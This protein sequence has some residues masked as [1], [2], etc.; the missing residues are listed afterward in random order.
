MLQQFWYRLLYKDWLINQVTKLD[1]DIIFLLR[2][3]NYQIGKIRQCLRPPL[4]LI[5][6][7]NNGDYIVYNDL[8][9]KAQ[10]SYQ[11]KQ[12]NECIINFYAGL[13]R[14]DYIYN[15]GKN[16]KYPLSINMQ[17]DINKSNVDLKNQHYWKNA[18][19]KAMSV[20]LIY[21]MKVMN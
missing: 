17:I 11:Y 4:G 9:F 21:L 13:I 20:I 15:A 1:N 16:E 2:L 12:K 7:C 8:V 5:K 19:M 6:N 3:K 10:Y 18:L 14:Y